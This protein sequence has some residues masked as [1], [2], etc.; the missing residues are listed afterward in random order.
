MNLK[1]ETAIRNN[2]VKKIME[3]IAAG[4]DMN[5]KGSLGISP[6]L[7]AVALGITDVVDVLLKRGVNVDEPDVFGTTPVHAA[8]SFNKNLSILKKIL[9]YV[10][11]I[12]ALDIENNTPFMAGVGNPAFDRYASE[13][14]DIMMKSGAN[15]GIENCSNENCLDRSVSKGFYDMSEA[16]MNS[17]CSVT[18][19]SLFFAVENRM[20]KMT[21]SLLRNGA[22]PNSRD[23]EGNT[24][25]II[26][27]TFG[28]VDIMVLLLDKG[29]D[30]ELKNKKG[31]TAEKMS[32]MIM[33]NSDSYRR[34]LIRSRL[35]NQESIKNKK[36][37]VQS[38][39]KETT[40]NEVPIENNPDNL[41]KRQK[42]KKPE[43]SEQSIESESEKKNEKKIN[44]ENENVQPNEFD[45]V[46]RNLFDDRN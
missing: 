21:E 11:N 1:L 34:A 37:S 19:K 8:C 25:F 6:I 2:D 4:C 28:L 44:I 3:F 22:E 40:T 30:P 7:L 41:K 43:Q 23:S 16:L 36:E 39:K 10:E 5:K 15:P 32:V 46:F 26:A 27:A 12:N 13:F 18:K 31:E 33:D 45:V 24:P 29:A 20:T 9:P 42:T 38:G 35:E 17:G 14:V